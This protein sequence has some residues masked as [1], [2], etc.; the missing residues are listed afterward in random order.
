ARAGDRARSETVARAAFAPVLACIDAF[1]ERALRPAPVQLAY[2]L[3]TCALARGD[4]RDALATL[5]AAERRCLE[6]HPNLLFLAASARE[7]LGETDAAER[8][9][10]ACLALDGRRFAI[11]VNPGFTAGAPR[12]RLA[13]LALLRGDAGSALELLEGIGGALDLPARLLRAEARLV[14]RD[15]ANALRELAPL[16]AGPA[17]IDPPPDLF[18]LAGWAAALSGSREPSL[19]D[20]ARRAPPERWI[21]PRRKSLLRAD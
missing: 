20:A 18:A 16:L 21:E 2:V 4:A 6:P 9:Y 7:R 11:P 14:R 1:S 15:A 8:L 19:L 13:S 5:E 3:A 12:L 17:S 10:R